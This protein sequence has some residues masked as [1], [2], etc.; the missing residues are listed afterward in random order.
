MKDEKVLNQDVINEEELEALS[1][2]ISAI[3]ETQVAGLQGANRC[4]NGMASPEE[5]QDQIL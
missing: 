2:G 3:L 5:S 1:G 4:C